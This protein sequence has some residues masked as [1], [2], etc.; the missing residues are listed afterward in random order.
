MPTAFQPVNPVASFICMTSRPQDLL[1]D[2]Q[3]GVLRK[4]LIDPKGLMNPGKIF[5]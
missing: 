4:K 3:P 1:A 2:V 5:L